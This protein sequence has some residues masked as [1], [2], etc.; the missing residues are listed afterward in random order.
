MGE[1]VGVKDHITS[2]SVKYDFIMAIEVKP[3]GSE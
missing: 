3:G 1:Q 2:G